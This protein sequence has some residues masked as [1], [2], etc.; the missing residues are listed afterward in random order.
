MKDTIPVLRIRNYDDFEKLWSQF[1]SKPVENPDE[2]LPYCLLLMYNLNKQRRSSF[3]NS[4]DI[5]QKI[6]DIANF[7]DHKLNTKFRFHFGYDYTCPYGGYC[8][9]SCGPSASENCNSDPPSQHL[10]QDI[11]Q[12]Y[13]AIDKECRK[14]AIDLSVYK[15]K[16]VVQAACED[17]K[18]P[19]E[20]QEVQKR[21]SEIMDGKNLN[22]AINYKGAPDPFIHVLQEI[23]FNSGYG[24]INCILIGT[25][26]NPDDS[27]ESQR[28]YIKKELEI[29][30]DLIEKENFPEI[31][32]LSVNS[33]YPIKSV[34]MELLCAITL[35]GGEKLAD[36]IQT[37]ES[38]SFKN[39]LI[40]VFIPL[41]RGYMDWDTA[42]TILRINHDLR[43]SENQWVIDRRFLEALFK[44]Y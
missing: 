24:Y 4:K 20:I 27:P 38:S 41:K 18:T 31:E 39:G 8:D 36:K 44:V 43:P 32:K 10:D 42:Q 11:D 12:V 1:K 22:F 13:K 26:Y 9:M 7:L 5:E 19:E 35:S 30:R 3:G 16:A 15:Y 40:K 28:K 14:W 37:V 25:R 29:L 6:C 2:I 21:F 23:L 17:I 34:V 33:M